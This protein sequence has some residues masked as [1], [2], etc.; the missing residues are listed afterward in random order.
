MAHGVVACV[1]DIGDIPKAYWFGL[2][3]D[4]KGLVAQIYWPKRPKTTQ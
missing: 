4:Q 2:K 3:D 1:I